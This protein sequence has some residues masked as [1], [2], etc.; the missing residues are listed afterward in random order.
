MPLNFENC[1]QGPQKDHFQENGWNIRGLALFLFWAYQK[2]KFNKLCS[3]RCCNMK[4]L[5][6]LLQFLT[7]LSRKLL[8]LNVPYLPKHRQS[9]AYKG[10]VNTNDSRHSASSLPG[11]P[12]VF[13]GPRK[14]SIAVFIFQVS[15]FC[16]L[17]GVSSNGFINLL[18]LIFFTFFEVKKIIS[19]IFRLK[20]MR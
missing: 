11:T 1:E 20:T 4:V 6:I 8:P 12:A 14:H 15:I 19:R 16:P 2:L 7:F 5:S 3:Y 9:Q 13:V 17:Q 10:P 18:R